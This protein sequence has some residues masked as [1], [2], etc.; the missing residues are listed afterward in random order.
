MTDELVG[1]ADAIFVMER[2][3]GKQ[4]RTRFGHSVGQTSIVCLDIPDDFEFMDDELVRRLE[5][6]MARHLPH[7]PSSRPS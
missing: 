7:V 4:V 3:H 1:W 6:R 5:G 2:R